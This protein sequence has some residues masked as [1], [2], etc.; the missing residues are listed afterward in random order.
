MDPSTQ[1]FS[2]SI[3]LVQKSF[4]QLAPD[5]DL[6]TD[7][8]FARLF[9]LDPTRRAPLPNDLRALKGQFMYAL[10]RAVRDLN[11]SREPPGGV[12]SN[13]RELL[14]TALLWTLEQG[15]GE[16]FTAQVREAW[17]CMCPQLVPAMFHFTKIA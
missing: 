13:E 17:A 4:A 7:L 10:S 3:A 2:Q 8:F 11:V 15:L 1:P 16:D 6:V 5:A 9:Q 14:E 12:E